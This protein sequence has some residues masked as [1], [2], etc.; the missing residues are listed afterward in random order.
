MSDT[1]ELPRDVLGEHVRE[2]IKLDSD[3]REHTRDG[4]DIDTWEHIDTATLEHIAWEDG[5]LH[6]W[7]ESETTVSERVARATRHQPA[8][9]RHHDADVLISVTWDF[10]PEHQPVVDIEVVQR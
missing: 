3:I 4:V 10:D 7:F 6:A 9:Y 5:N 8:E 1:V 2:Q